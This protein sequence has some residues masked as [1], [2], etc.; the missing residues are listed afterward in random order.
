VAQYLSRIL[1][2]L[3]PAIGVGLRRGA[4]RAPDGLTFGPSGLPPSRTQ[5]RPLAWADKFGTF[6]ASCGDWPPPLS[7]LPPR[8]SNG[9][10]PVLRLRPRLKQGT[11]LGLPTAPPTRAKASQRVLPPFAERSEAMGMRPLA[12]ARRFAEVDNL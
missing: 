12:K 4:S 7:G 3:C 9:Q 5:P 8:L 1:T 6:G 11:L 2:Q 10:T